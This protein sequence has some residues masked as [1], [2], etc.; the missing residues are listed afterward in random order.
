MEYDTASSE[1]EPYREIECKRM[2]ES[3]RGGV[4][5]V[6][7]WNYYILAPF[8]LLMN[9]VV[10]SL[11]CL[12]M[13]WQRTFCCY[14][15]CLRF[16]Y[17]FYQYLFLPLLHVTWIL[18]IY[19]IFYT[20][21]YVNYNA[22]LCIKLFDVFFFFIKLNNAFFECKFPTTAYFRSQSKFIFKK[23]TKKI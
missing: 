11:I 15:K 20:F 21:L 7:T 10:Y 12:K 5:F 2:T 18:F 17:S 14:S 16:V 19:S 8:D 22:F 13:K 9:G 4:Y 23:S 6:T 3:D 1:G